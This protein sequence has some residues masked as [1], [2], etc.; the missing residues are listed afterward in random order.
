MGFDSKDS[1]CSWTKWNEASRTKWGEAECNVVKGYKHKRNLSAVYEDF[2]RD[3]EAKQS[4]ALYSKRKSAAQ[5]TLSSWPLQTERSEGWR[6]R[7]KLDTFLCVIQMSR[8]K[9][10]KTE[11]CIKVL[12]TPRVLAYE[13]CGVCHSATQCIAEN[14]GAGYATLA[15]PKGFAPHLS[16]QTVLP[17]S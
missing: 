1:L 15:N 12:P 9:Q 2:V 16:T 17:T 3:L 11:E 13:A 14:K 7:K 8:A 4:L 10:Y 5:Q 6:R